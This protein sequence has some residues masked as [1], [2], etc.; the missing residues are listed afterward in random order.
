MPTAGPSD[1]RLVAPSD[2][3]QPCRGVDRGN[4]R[5]ITIRSTQMSHVLHEELAR[6]HMQQRL[7]QAERQRLADYVVRVAKARRH[8]QRARRQLEQAQL[9]L[10]LLQG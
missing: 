9:R 3:T 5:Q 8:A 2:P 1:D 7:A 10:R 4:V 6:A